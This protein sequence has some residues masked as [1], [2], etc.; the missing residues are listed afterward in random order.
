M[1]E[2]TVFELNLVSGAKEDSNKASYTDGI[3]FG[4]GLGGGIASLSQGASGDLI[5]RGA[6][7][8]GLVGL[9]GV[10]GWNFGTYL[11]EDTRVGDWVRTGIDK[12]TGLDKAGI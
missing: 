12:V 2:L 9:A 7:R 5:A 4:A 8:G 1:R 10:A 6:A 3:N 11:Y